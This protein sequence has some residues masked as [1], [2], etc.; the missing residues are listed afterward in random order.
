MSFCHMVEDSWMT[1]HSMAILDH[2]DGI[3]KK[4]LQLGLGRSLKFIFEHSLIKY[5]NI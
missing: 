5:S 4:V 3:K 1:R 2:P